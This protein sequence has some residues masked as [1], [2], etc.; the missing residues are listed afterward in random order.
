M[1]I[2]FY[3][4]K[5]QY[6]MYKNEYE[7]A[8]LRVLRSG[9]YILGEE[10]GRFENEFKTYMG[11]KNC[12]GVGNGLDALR[13]A[14]AALGVG[15]GDEV[16]VQTNTFIATVLAITEI[17]ATPI[18]V[19]VDSYFGID[20]EAIEK[21][22]TA[23][24]KA[25]IVVHLYGQPCEM[26]MIMKIANK[27]NLY[28][29]EDCAQ[30]HGARYKGKLVGTIGNVGCFSFYPTKPVGAFGDSG[31][32]I[33]DNDEVDKKIRMLRNYGSSIK[34]KHELL[35]INSRMDEVQAAIVKINLKH[36]E[37]GN[38]KRVSIALKYIN[39][40]KNQEIKLPRIR[41]DT[42][43]VFHIFP[44][45]CIRREELKKYL[46][47]YGIQTQIHYPICCH[48][49]ECYK[50]LSYKIGD[51]PKAEKYM[52][53]ELSLPIYNELKDKE[54]K[55]IISTINNFK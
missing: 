42:L 10:L 46:E 4:L 28:V 14:M 3:N 2:E 27:H 33:T 47:S 16:I 45:H 11:I 12:I 51:F 7:E 43:N 50:W 39:E 25:V 21:V 26:D 38:K 52:K 55:Y 13:L 20:S 8:T 31:A 40:I 1:N 49:S 41:P 18:F 48:I 44:I 53:E 9:W 24:T 54:L 22:I 37:E 36:L 23:K 19:D 29:I 30:A 35:G 34:Y 6:N 15:N 32:I 5:R 17:G